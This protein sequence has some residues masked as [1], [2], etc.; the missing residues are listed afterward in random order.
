MRST[1]TLAYHSVLS[2]WKSFLAHDDGK[3]EE[4]PPLARVVMPDVQQH[5]YRAYP[6]ALG[7]L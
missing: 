3:P 1:F 5:R 2:S 7:A 4:V 6:L